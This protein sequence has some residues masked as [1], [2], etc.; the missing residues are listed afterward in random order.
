MIY[1]LIWDHE[2][3]GKQV[4]EGNF[5]HEGAIAEAKKLPDGANHHASRASG[6]LCMKI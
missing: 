4:V 1:I 3:E 5:N 6:R 2:D